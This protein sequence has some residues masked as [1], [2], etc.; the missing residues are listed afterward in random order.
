[1]HTNFSLL[2]QDHSIVAQLNETTVAES[3]LTS[4]VGARF[5]DR[6]PHYAWTMAYI[7]PLQ[8]C[9]VQGVWC[10]GVTCHLHF[11]QDDRGLLHATVER[12]LNK[13][14]DSFFV[15]EPDL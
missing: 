15:R 2:C 12:T 5:R 1:M 6:F 11:W 9:W 4:C 7:R 10:L 14:Q 8:L 3:S 13:G